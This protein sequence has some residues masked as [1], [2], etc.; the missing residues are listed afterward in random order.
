[1][2]E[3]KLYIEGLANGFQF[4]RQWKNLENFIYTL[5]KDVEDFEDTRRFYSS[6]QP[7]VFDLWAEA[8]EILCTFKSTTEE[9]AESIL[10]TCFEQL[11]ELKKDYRNVREK[12]LDRMV[13]QQKRK[14][15][16]L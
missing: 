10:E 7:D 3:P 8:N 16:H 2:S 4:G 13:H 14:R 9:N 1:M 6:L 11:K 12:H 15:R 5:M